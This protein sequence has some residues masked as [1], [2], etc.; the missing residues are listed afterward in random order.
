MSSHH[1]HTRQRAQPVTVDAA[2][3]SG[4]DASARLNPK[5]SVGDTPDPENNVPMKGSLCHE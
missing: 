5:L 4:D 1:R 3:R 2:T